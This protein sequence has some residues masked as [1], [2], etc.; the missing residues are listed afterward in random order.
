I[1]RSPSSKL[2]GT[3]PISGI[4]VD[5]NRSKN[6]KAGDATTLQDLGKEIAQLVEMLEDGKRRSIHQPMRDTIVSIQALYERLA[7]QT[8]EQ[9]RK[10]APKSH[11]ASQTSPLFRPLAEPRRKGTGPD[12]P[13]NMRS[14][15]E[16]A[17]AAS[18]TRAE[19]RTLGQTV[20]PETQASKEVQEWKLVGP[21]KKLPKKQRATNSIPKEKP[22]P[23]ALVITAMGESSYA[24]I[25]RRV[26][27][28]KKLQGLGEAVSKI[29]RTQKGELLLQLKRSGEETAAFKALVSESVGDQVEVRSL[30]HKIEIECRDLDEITTK[31]EVSEAIG[32]LVESPG[33]PVSDILLR[34]AFGQTQTAIIRLPA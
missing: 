6:Q 19:A 8:G 11:Q 26:K 20:E 24:D 23:D 12:P 2:G 14:K 31:E 18:R 34:K 21:R 32:K 13:N 5:Q 33:V 25:L 15:R 28:D 10:E 16:T 1:A 22:R 4:R 3:P 30:S 17:Q 9:G 29:R 7:S 27:Q